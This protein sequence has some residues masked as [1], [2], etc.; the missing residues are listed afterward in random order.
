MPEFTCQTHINPNYVVNYDRVPSASCG[1]EMGYLKI[2]HLTPKMKLTG[3]QCILNDSVRL[4]ASGD[5]LDNPQVDIAIQPPHSSSWLSAYQV[6]LLLPTEPVTLFGS[7]GRIS[8]EPVVDGYDDDHLRNGEVVFG[9][10]LA[11][12]GTETVIKF[13]YSQIGY[14]ASVHQNILFL[15]TVE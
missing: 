10:N 14:K 1:Y 3:L 4:Q 2:H 13:H 15:F 9:S 11:T 12:G 8:S 5:G 7:G 6:D